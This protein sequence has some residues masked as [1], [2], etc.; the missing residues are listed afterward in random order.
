M[1]KVLVGLAFLST[2]VLMACPKPVKKTEKEIQEI[3]AM[4]LQN[5]FASNGAGGG[6]SNTHNATETAAIREAACQ[7]AAADES[8]AAKD[9]DEKARSTNRDMPENLIVNNNPYEEDGRMHNAI[10]DI[11]FE[12]ENP[13]D[14]NTALKNYNV[15]AYNKIFSKSK[16]KDIYFTNPTDV[17]NNLKDNHI[18]EQ[19]A[20]SA[21]QPITDEN[22]V[23]FNYYI[24]N[25]CKEMK[26]DGKSKY[27]RAVFLNTEIT[28]ILNTIPAET[29]PTIEQTLKLVY[30]TTYKYSMYYWKDMP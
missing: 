5:C 10:L 15:E 19:V 9:G 30:L 25:H 21:I 2:L 26:L 7:Q 3:D 29:N 27:E 22:I 18:A 24:N 6:G 1:K 28:N 4:A 13:E 8:Q 11:Y 16:Y 17:V 12:Y 23:S 20:E 14:F